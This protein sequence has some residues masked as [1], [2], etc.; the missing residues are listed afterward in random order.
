VRTLGTEGGRIV[1]VALW[2]AVAPM[3]RGQPPPLAVEID[4]DL[5]HGVAAP[6]ERVRDGGAGHDRD[7][8]LR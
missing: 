2:P 5:T 4:Q 6:G 1:V 3:L 7:V 8:M